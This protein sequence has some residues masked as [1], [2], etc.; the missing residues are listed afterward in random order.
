[1]PE[2]LLTIPALQAKLAISRTALWAV[3]K[4][5]DFPRPV[6]VGVSSKRYVESEV[7]AWMRQQPRGAGSAEPDAGATA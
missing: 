1:M 6:I 3:R 2:Q 7:D 5:P 4:L